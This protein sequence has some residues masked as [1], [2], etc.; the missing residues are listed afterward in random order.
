MDRFEKHL[1]KFLALGVVSCA[2]LMPAGIWL[3][4][5]H[6]DAPGLEP[7]IIILC[8]GIAC[9]VWVLGFI[10][11]GIFTFKEEA[12]ARPM[13]RLDLDRVLPKPEALPGIDVLHEID[14]QTTLP[15][16]KRPCN[17]IRRNQTVL[18]LPRADRSDTL[19]GGD[20]TGSL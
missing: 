10:L 11:L 14:I 19:P 5:K 12:P 7:A 17:E 8:I 4:K 18:D 15:A 16:T 6:L 2:L 1:L 9:G 3:T 13:Y 20:Q